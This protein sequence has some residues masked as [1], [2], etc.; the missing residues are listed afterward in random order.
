MVDDITFNERSAY[1]SISWAAQR[2]GMTKS[3][4]LRK[5]ETLEHEG[6]PSRDPLTNLYHKADVDAWIDR[7]RRIQDVDIAAFAEARNSTEV[8]LDAL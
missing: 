8:N 1:G 7:R 5:R 3:Q 6:F 2:L 4:F